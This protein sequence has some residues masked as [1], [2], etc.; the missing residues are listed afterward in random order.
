MRSML[1]RYT[2]LWLIVLGSPAAA[3]LSDTDRAAL[4]ESLEVLSRGSS[5]QAAARASRI[6]QD[7]DVGAGKWDAFFLEFF[8]AHALTDRL[9][10][11]LSRV[12]LDARPES[13]AVPLQDALAH[14][15]ASR[16]EPLLARP[17]GRL[18]RALDRDRALF[19]ELVSAQQ[20]LGRLAYAGDLPDASRRALAARLIRPIGAHPEVLH[21]SATLDTRSQ[22]RLAA[23]RAHL[24][25][26]LRDLPRPFDPAAFVA[27]TGFAG[28]RAELVERHGLIVLDNNGFDAEQLRAI[29]HLL[30]VIPPALHETTH[31][32]QNDSLG[33]VVNGK[34]E[35]RFEGSPGVNIFA[36]EIG[37]H[38]ADQFPEDGEPGVVSS[39]CSVLQ[40]E[41]NH[42]V[43]AVTIRK[44]P[45]LLARRD[46]L[47]EQAAGRDS[48]AFLRS[49]I[50]PGYFS[51]HPQEFFASI[52]NQYLSDT[53]KT[54]LLALE[55][56]ESGWAQPL[57]QLLFF[58]D[59]YSQGSDTTLFFEQDGECGYTVYAVPL[60]RDEQ[61]RIE[62]LT[63]EGVEMRFRLDANGDV[64]P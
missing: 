52:A 18:S 21:A 37:R 33:N 61:G 26:N 64:R 34:V 63:W 47:I 5:G 38:R 25:K 43:D 11:F 56:V 54:L 51:R 12:S 40:H 6:L 14:A 27:A 32:S 23:I 19:E 48:R 60:G 3:E 1:L 15:A 44:H 28:A 10:R 8:E 22:P 57:N 45:Q 53:P 4:E 36:I 39:F 41:L 55:R 59:V 24:Y 62:R 17:P 16:I 31:I 42:R 30:D 29:R 7:P 9:G 49:M 2:L 35:V 50:E 46:A 58:A 13:V 20:L